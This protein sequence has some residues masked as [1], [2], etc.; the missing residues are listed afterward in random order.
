MAAVPALAERGVYLF[1]APGADPRPLPRVAGGEE[2]IHQV[3]GLALLEVLQ[4]P[5]LRPAFGG[6]QFTRGAHEEVVARDARN[7]IRFQH[8]AKLS[9]QERVVRAVDFLHQSKDIAPWSFTPSMKAGAGG[10][11]HER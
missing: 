7:V 6:W 4:H 9:H 5:Q 2:G 8:V 10:A 3:T 1:A 11:R